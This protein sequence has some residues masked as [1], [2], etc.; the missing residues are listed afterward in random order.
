DMIALLETYGRNIPLSVEVFTTDPREM[1]AQVDEFLRH[2]GLYSK[3]YVKIPIGWNELIVIHKLRQRGINVNCTCC[4]S[5]NQ[6]IMP[7]EAGENY[8]SL[9]WG[10]IRDIGYDA[11]SIVRKVRQT[12]KEWGTPTEII[13]GSIRHIADINE[14][15]QAG[16]D[17]ITIP[18]K[19]FPQL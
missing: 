5:Y 8:V 14:A 15:I 6:A 1:F 10:R 19:F 4:M 7:A 16:A 17:I 3:L 18:P 11:G 12:F 13:I 9:F 2:F